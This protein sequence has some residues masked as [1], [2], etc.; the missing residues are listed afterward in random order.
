MRGW[1]VVIIAIVC[2]VVGGIGGTMLG[3]GAGAGFGIV[4]GLLSGSQ[5]GVCLAV[6]TAKD[7]G[8]LAQDKANALVSATIGKIKSVLPANVVQGITWMT[9]EQDC[10]N[11]V[12]ELKQKIAA[13]K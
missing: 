10:A 9:N 2:L 13:S 11:K 8:I 4:A 7:Q 5:A 6:E 1:V 12:A 3:G